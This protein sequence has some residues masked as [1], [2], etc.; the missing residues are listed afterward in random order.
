GVTSRARDVVMPDGDLELGLVYTTP[1]DQALADRPHL[2][3][4][5][6]A[7]TGPEIGD[8]ELRYRDFTGGR[9]YWTARSGAHL[10]QGAILADYLAAGGPSVFGEPIT[11]ELTTPDGVGRYSKFYHNGPDWPASSYWSPATG[12]HMVY[13]LIA[14]RWAALGWE[15]GPFGYPTTDEANTNKAGGRYNNFQHGLIVWSAGTGAHS[16]GGAI[17]DKY[18]ASNWDWGVLGFPTTDELDTAKPGGKYNNFEF[19]TIVWSAGTGA[20]M[21]KGDN[22]LK[23]GEY[24]YDNGLLGFPTTSEVALPGGA[25]NHVQGGSI[26]WSPGA[27]SHAIY[28]AFRNRWAALGWERSYLGFP[29]SEEFS[30]TGGRRQNFQYGYMVWDSRTGAVTDRRY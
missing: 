2:A 27:G 20:Q 18:A 25:Y 7:P 16:V 3:Q 19:G 1:I 29:T 17:L 4:K 23:W 12:A 11:D 5:A 21:V 30:V 14:Q 13:G 22:L 24:G 26:Y 28:G 10:V 8:P 9:M 15:K 6:G